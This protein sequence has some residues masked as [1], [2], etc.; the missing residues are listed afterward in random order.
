M[1][2]SAMP[3]LCMEFCLP[4]GVAF[5][6]SVRTCAR[7]SLAMEKQ[8]GIFAYGTVR[9]LTERFRPRPHVSGSGGDV[10]LRFQKYTR[11]QVVYL[12]RFARPMGIR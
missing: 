3:M 8:Q 11:P 1:K 2:A 4:R 6:T 5:C 9:L 7:T 10:F 12:N